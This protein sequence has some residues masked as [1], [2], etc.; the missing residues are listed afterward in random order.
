MAL[1]DH[2]LAAALPC[3][4]AVDDLIAQIADGVAPIDRVHQATCRHCQAALEAIR[5][6]WEE[7][8]LAARATIALPEELTDRILHRIRRLRR[9]TGDGVVIAAP[10]G[11]TR[12]GSRVLAGLARSSAMSV[13]EVRLATVLSTEEDPDEP[14]SVVVELRLVVGFGPPMARVAAVVRERVDRTLRRQAG[15]GASRVEIA[16]EDLVVDDGR[17]S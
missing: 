2:G 15:I 16:I 17:S 6:V 12:V 14:G 5:E 9:A 10:Q 8:Q 1:D 11:E 13:P 7:F 3:G 4:T